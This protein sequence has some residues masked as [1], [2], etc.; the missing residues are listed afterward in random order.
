VRWIAHR[1]KLGRIWNLIVVYPIRR[2]AKSF[3]VHGKKVLLLNPCAESPTETLELIRQTMDQALDL[4]KQCAPHQ[5]EALI[6]N[7]DQFMVL[8]LQAARGRFLSGSRECQIGLDVF[9]SNGDS[10]LTV[11]HDVASIIIHEATHARFHSI[12]KT[13]KPDPNFR[14]EKLCRKAERLFIEKA[15]SAP[16]HPWP[17]NYDAVYHTRFGHRLAWHY[18]NSVTSDLRD[19]I[20]TMIAS[21]DGEQS[22]RE[23]ESPFDIAILTNKQKYLDEFEDLKASL[24]IE[25]QDPSAWSDRGFRFYDLRQWELAAED[26]RRATEIDPGQLHD[27][28]WL[29][30]VSEKLNSPKDAIAAWRNV[31]SLEPEDATAVCALVRHTLR[32]AHDLPNQLLRESDAAEVLA[33]ADLNLKS[34]PYCHNAMLTRGEVLLYCNEPDQAIKIAEQAMIYH[35]NCK[36]GLLLAMRASRA[37]GRSDESESYWLSYLESLQSE[38]SALDDA[39]IRDAIVLDCQPKGYSLMLTVLVAV[40]SEP[41]TVDDLARTLI[42]NTALNSSEGAYW[43]W[44]LRSS[45]VYPES[46]RG[47]CVRIQ[48]I[49]LVQEFFSE[50]EV[51]RPLDHI[52]LVLSDSDREAGYLSES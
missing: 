29:A 48:K 8:Q 16:D 36:S 1:L 42:A 13:H 49:E 9:L 27:W 3:S 50:T 17:A 37:L 18:A 15:K 5:Y 52:R 20:Q 30:F 2:M 46:S 26:F 32:L 11:V 31:R 44:L 38:I 7:V 12:R 24:S 23:K 40:D 21:I 34:N 19:R 14:E 22:V 25:S 28:R 35:P 51:P 33:L 6:R 10:G 47:D 43:R 4:I 45:R 39:M 41:E